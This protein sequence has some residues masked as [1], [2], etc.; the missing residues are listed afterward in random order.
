VLPLY[1]GSLT[2]EEEE[3]LPSDLQ[4]LEGE[5]KLQT[6]P[7]FRG[8]VL[9]ILFLLCSTRDAR[10]VVRRMNVYPILREYHLSERDEQLREAVERV[11]D[12]VMRSEEEVLMDGVVPAS[13]E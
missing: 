4:F 10:D 9:D 3:A 6:D 8:V 2:P 13:D 5:K 1:T 7:E 11:V 12:L